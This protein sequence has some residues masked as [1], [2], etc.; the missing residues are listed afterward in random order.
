[1][2]QYHILVNLTKKEFVH[3]HQIGNGLKIMEQIGWDFS[4]STALVMLL[5]GS[6][7]GGS[8]GGGDFH[9]EHSLVGSWAGDRVAFVGDYAEDGDVLGENSREIYEACRCDVW[10]NIS[11][12][13]REMMAS[14]FHITYSGSGWL[15][16]ESPE[17]DAE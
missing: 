11:S 15:N 7:K 2:G 4:T 16:I 9:T 12:D 8:R 5:A 3:P 13:V 1:M 17:V 6:C 10:K 14:E